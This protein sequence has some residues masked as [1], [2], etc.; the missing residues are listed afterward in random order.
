MS[1][2]ILIDKT[3]KRTLSLVSR[4][5]TDS[6]LILGHEKR[7]ISPRSLNE[8]VITKAANYLKLTNASFCSIELISKSYSGYIYKVLDC[9]NKIFIYKKF[10]D[11]DLFKKEIEIINILKHPCHVRTNN[12]YDIKSGYFMEEG[13]SMD[14]FNFNTP[15]EFFAYMCDVCSGLEYMHSMNMIHMDIK[16]NNIIITN[17]GAKIIDYGGYAIQ[18]HNLGSDD[19]VAFTIIYASPEVILNDRLITCKHDIWSFGITLSE[20]LFDIHPFMGN[21]DD[22]NDEFDP[23]TAKEY[24]INVYRKKNNMKLVKS[25]MKYDI[26][27]MFKYIFRYNCPKRIDATTLRN[28]IRDIINNYV[29]KEYH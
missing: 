24:L 16:P 6:T 17:V 26:Y 28:I 19:K 29:I 25:N 11:I 3:K 13:I 23:Q 21:F 2:N 5:D 20:S 18:P 27:N 12:I 22:V 14:L 10:S 1:Y 9:K 7:E 15:K 8:K 4:T